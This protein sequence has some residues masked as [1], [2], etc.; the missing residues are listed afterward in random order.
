MKSFIPKVGEAAGK[1]FAPPWRPHH[2]L[3]PTNIHRDKTDVLQAH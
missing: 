1:I 3:T 2:L